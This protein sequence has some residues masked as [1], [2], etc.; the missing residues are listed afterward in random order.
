MVGAKPLGDH[1]GEWPFINDLGAIKADGERLD[2]FARR[3]NRQAADGRRIN[4]AAQQDSHRHVR[5]HVLAHGRAQQVVKLVDSLVEGHR[6]ALL[7]KTKIPIPMRGDTRRLGD[8]IMAGQEF[9][10]SLKQRFF[11]RQ[12]VERQKLSNRRHVH[13]PA[14]GWIGK[15]GFQLRGEPQGAAVVE[16]VQRLDAH[17][18]ARH[19]QS[20]SLRVPNGE[21][22]HPAELLDA[23]GTLVLV[24]MHDD[25]RVGLRA[26]HV[27]PLDQ[28]LPEFLKVVNL[29]R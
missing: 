10:H 4:P 14:N 2:L 21:R 23:L 24:Q 29:A 16:I 20:A 1:S 9:A 26:K 6:R 12:V 15:D 27:P 25:F 19:E 13:L 17:A 5:N 28:P 3:L 7:G 8:Q 22:K 11:P 18:V